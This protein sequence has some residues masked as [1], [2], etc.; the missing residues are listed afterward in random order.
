MGW[1]V[2][3][4][5]LHHHT[6][7]FR[8]GWSHSGPW[9]GAMDNMHG[10]KQPLCTIPDLKCLCSGRADGFSSNV[11]GLGTSSFSGYTSSSIHSAYFDCIEISSIIYA[12]Q[13]L[14]NGSVILFDG[15]RQRSI[16]VDQ[17]RKAKR[18]RS[19]NRPML[20][21]IN[22]K[23]WKKLQTI[24]LLIISIHVSWYFL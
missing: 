22:L 9:T 13:L 5:T 8:K 2:I 18:E 23:C 12:C 3:S 19:W 20:S 7:W 16:L 17:R 11:C 4:C 24:D 14:L 1:Y 6:G 21:E 15:N 10:V